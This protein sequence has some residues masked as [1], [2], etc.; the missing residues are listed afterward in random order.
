MKQENETDRSARPPFY[1]IARRIDLTGMSPATHG[2]NRSCPA[3]YLGGRMD[4]MISPAGWH[5]LRRDEVGRD[6]DEITREI[7]HYILFTANNGLVHYVHTSIILK[8][9]AVARGMT[10]I[11]LVKLAIEHELAASP[12]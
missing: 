7:P 5:G 11:D 3:S 4:G 1:R 9:E 12:R 6:L 2:I 10:E 8:A